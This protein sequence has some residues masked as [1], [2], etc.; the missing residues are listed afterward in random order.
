MSDQSALYPLLLEPALH[1]RVWGGRRLAEIMHKRLPTDEPYGESWELHDTVTVMNG[2]LAGRRLGDLA[3]EY[4][5]ALIGEG[6]DPAKGLPLLVKF[7]DASEWL[8]IQVHPDDSQAAALEGEPRGKTEAWIMLAADPGAQLVI[9]VR[10]GI[11]REAMAQAIRDNA[12]E[13]LLVYADVR[14]GDVLYLAAG[15]IHALGP[16]LLIYEIQ[17]SSDTTYRL[18]DWGRMGLDG[19]PRQLHIEKGVQVSNLT[20]L[21]QISHPGSD[22]APVSTLVQGNYFS[23]M[24]YRLDETIRPAPHLDPRGQFQALT[25]ISGQVSVGYPGEQVAFSTGQTVMIPAAHEPVMLHGTGEVVRSWQG[26][27]ADQP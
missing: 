7:L 11:T 15:T 27:G 12:L 14:A 21:P 6:N 13:S 19:K 10:P 4:G 25:C 26:D 9:G 22:D 8:S 24:R 3:Q 1:I 17:Q 2:P 20:S 16:S 23:T 18:Y 5:A